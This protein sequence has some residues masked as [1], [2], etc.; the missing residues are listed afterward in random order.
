MDNHDDQSKP[1]NQVAAAPGVAQGI[2]QSEK[3]FIRTIAEKL[4]A[5]IRQYAE[6]NGLPDHYTQHLEFVVKHDDGGY[7]IG[8]PIYALG[9]AVRGFYDAQGMMNAYA[10]TVGI[11]EFFI[12]G[13]T[14]YKVDGANLRDLLN[15]Y[16]EGFM[17]KT[18]PQH[19][20]DIEETAA[21]CG[22]DLDTQHEGEVRAVGLTPRAI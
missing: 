19:C 13:R 2:V 4:Q 21:E 7:H 18:N 22:Y 16:N 8:V 5:G 11:K 3:L 1:T 9:S 17:R 15:I 14:W 6:E 10:K 20:V 12:H